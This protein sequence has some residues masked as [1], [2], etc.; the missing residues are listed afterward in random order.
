M[1]VYVFQDFAGTRWASSVSRY[2]VLQILS[3]NQD[4]IVLHL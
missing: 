1:V 4:Q 3:S 2:V